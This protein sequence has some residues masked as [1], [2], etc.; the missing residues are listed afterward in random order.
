MST[1]K[2]LQEIKTSL[3]AQSDINEAGTT[4]LPSLLLNVSSGGHSSELDA[5]LPFYDVLCR[6][7]HVAGKLHTL[8]L[9]S[10]KKHKESSPLSAEYWALTIC[11]L[12]RFANDEIEPDQ[13][14]SR[15]LRLKM[16]NAALCALD[17]EVISS[18]LPFRDELVTLSDQILNSLI[19]SEQQK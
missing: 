16:L 13:E 11:M 10:W 6:K 15:G 7:I 5:N 12:L 17:L 1:D 9:K 14:H 2:L 19:L 18:T 8:Y 3:A 4:H